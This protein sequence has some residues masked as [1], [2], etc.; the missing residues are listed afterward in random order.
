MKPLPATFS[1]HWPLD[2]CWRPADWGRPGELLKAWLPGS[3]LAR[4]TAPDGWLLCWPQTQPAIAESLPGWAV[5]RHGGLWQTAPLTATQR[6]GHCDG[7][8]LVW[9][10]RLA[11]CA[12]QPCDPSNLLELAAYAVWTEPATPAA[13]LPAAPVPSAAAAHELFDCLPALSAERAAVLRALR[14]ETVAPEQAWW[15]RIARSLAL[16]RMPAPRLSSAR[17]VGTGAGTRTRPGLLDRLLGAVQRWSGLA[18]MVRQQHRRY[19]RDVLD[20]LERRDWQRML[21]HALPLADSGGPAGRADSLMRLLGPRAA[22]RYT[23]GDGGAAVTLAQDFFQQM[24]MHYRRAFEALDRA[25]QVDEAAYVLAELLRSTDEALAYLGKHGKHRTAAELATLRELPPARQLGLWLRA[26]ERDR[27][28]SLALRHQAFQ[29]AAQLFA[30]EAELQAQLRLLWGQHLLTLGRPAE[31]VDVMWPVPALK[32]RLI[33]LLRTVEDD[34]LVED[35]RLL[36]RAVHLLP[37]RFETQWSA[38]QRLLKHPEDADRALLR[39]FAQALSAASATA[40]SRM[41]A[42]ESLRA[43]L[44]DPPAARR[45]PA[46]LDALLRHADDPYLHADHVE[47]PQPPAS[48]SRPL[49]AVLLP[50]IAPRGSLDIVALAAAADG[51]V[52][53]GLGEDGCLRM[54]RAGRIRQRWRTPA[55]SFSG[56]PGGTLWIARQARARGSWACE[57]LAAGGQRLPS[58]LW[59][60]SAC[61]PHLVDGLWAV[62]PGEGARVQL[63]DMTRTPPACVWDSG[64]LPARVRALELG[65]R[66][67]CV[68]LGGQPDSGPVQLWHYRFPGL[69]LA[70]RDAMPPH[71]VGSA[72][73][74]DSGGAAWVLEC[75]QDSS[76]LRRVVAG[77]PRPVLP[78]TAAAAPLSLGLPGGCRK[79]TPI[80]AGLFITW[81]EAGGS[82]GPECLVLDPAGG[83]I[84]LRWAG[85][86]AHGREIAA[87]DPRWLWI[88][89]DGALARLERSSG[90]LR[91]LLPG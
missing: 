78:R 33:D 36:A 37:E 10:G 76:L 72:L 68:L 48:V 44:L 60:L 77:T 59:P 69:D 21:R 2:G 24:Q 64:I 75:G 1:G 22:L 86:P 34:P 9:E 42:R 49:D 29:S 80:G 81:V 51:S 39:H 65:P 71:H 28:L 82:S 12:L 5:Q 13:S 35:V 19:L 84:V 47:L 45:D 8:L 6:G 27:A 30:G 63:L 25:G 7:L 67:L 23:A 74:P 70:A 18:G 79:L 46:L 57:V 52:L 55:S 26:G 40:A 50:A 56:E 87:A 11:H 83:R 15:R 43:L 54:D 89:R 66:G 53:L 90:E 58:L 16:S 41:F 88:A 61:A 62:A 31:A 20:A 3:M 73:W 85:A 32:P 91:W 17:A 14:E 38:F 4:T